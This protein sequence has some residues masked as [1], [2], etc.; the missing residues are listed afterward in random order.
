MNSWTSV[1]AVALGGALGASLRYAVGLFWVARADR[2]PMSTLSVN[3][4]GCLVAG[5][6]L[7]SVATR[8]PAGSPYGL[9]LMTGVL[10]AFTT[11]SAFSVDTLRLAQSGQWSIAVLNVGLNVVLCLAAVAIGAWLGGVLLRVSG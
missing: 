8:M 11:F 4:L 9:F 6:L 10:G 7:T 2:W 3:V 5:V 1:L